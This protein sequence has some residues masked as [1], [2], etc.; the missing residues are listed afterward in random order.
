MTWFIEWIKK[1]FGIEPRTSKNELDEAKG[2]QDIYESIEGIN[3]TAIISNKLAKKTVANSDLSVEG[4]SKR[5]L[6]LSDC[7]ERFWDKALSVVSMAYGLGGIVIIP[8]VINGKGYIDIVPQSLFT[9]NSM[10]GDDI[11]S[12]CV[13]A[14]SFVRNNKKYY[15]MCEYSL[16]EGSYVIKNRA[17]VDNRETSLALVDCWAG[18]PEEIIIGN[19]ERMLFAYLT[20]PTDSRRANFGRGVSVTYG[21]ESLINDAKGVLKDIA[22]EY[23]LKKPM[24]AISEMAYDDKE[25]KLPSIFKTFPGIDNSDFWQLFNPDIRDASLFAR[26]NVQL[27]LIE[28]AVGVSEGILTKSSANA[29]TA[30]EIKANQ[31]DTFVTVASMR[32]NIDRAM[33]DL[34]YALSVLANYY[35]LNPEGEF[36]VAFDWDLSLMEYATETWLQLKEG[37][38]I[39]TISKAEIRQFLKGGTLEDAQKII[40]E[41]AKSEPSLDGLLGG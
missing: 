26:L 10:Q 40:D 34:A 36:Y 24:I 30:T 39:G 20:C 38:S 9:I 6:W 35:S 3:F 5:A 13:I 25:K 14:E 31:Y 27:E 28:K 18:L 12:A 7:L 1:M 4:D 29:M 16:S 22:D 15:R 32:K 37:S 23:S 19:V 21:A 2:M 8:Y 41:I 17:F 33:N 11:T